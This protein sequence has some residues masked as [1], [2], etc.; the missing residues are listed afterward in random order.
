MISR[1]EYISRPS[2]EQDPQR[3]RVSRKRQ[4]WSSCAR[5]APHS[6]SRPRPAG[7]APAPS[8]R[9]RPAPLPWPDRR[10]P[11][12][13]P[14]RPARRAPFRRHQ[15]QRAP[16]DRDDRPEPHRPTAPFRHRLQGLAQPAL[17][18]LQEGQRLALPRAQRHRQRDLAIQPRHPQRESPRPG[19]PF[20][21]NL[22]RWRARAGPAMKNP[23]KPCA[24]IA[25]CR[26]HTKGFDSRLHLWQ[27]AAFRV[28]HHPKGSPCP[29]QN[30][31]RSASARQPASAST[32]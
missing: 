4:R 3:D 12:A 5:P 7:P 1:Q 32:T 16:L 25:I 20:Q 31:A 14:P 8:A 28:T 29:K 27:A 26:W 9:P 6:G 11:A 15:R 24:N 10:A 17:M 30:G 19:R 23:L 13:D 18:A 2:G 21:M 22:D